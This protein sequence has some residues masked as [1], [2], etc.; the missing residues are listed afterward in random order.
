MIHKF[1]R[2]AKLRLNVR[3][4][5]LHAKGLRGVMATVNEIDAQFLRERVAPVRSLT[6]DEGVDACFGHRAHL[7]ARAAGH[8]ADFAAH[9]RSS[10]AHMH[11]RAGGG[12]ETLHEFITADLRLDLRT[13]VGALRLHE[14]TAGFETE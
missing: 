11:T 13:V 3:R 6:G 2:D 7:G 8:D 1:P 12:F 10:R 5:S 14:V 9:S 4:Q